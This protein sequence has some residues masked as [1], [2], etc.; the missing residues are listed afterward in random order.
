MLKSH[1]NNFI[2]SN[3]TISMPIS[4]FEAYKYEYDLIGFLNSKG[5]DKNYHWFIMILNNMSAP[6]QFLKDKVSIVIPDFGDIN[7]LKNVF[8]QKNTTF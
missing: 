5:I 8:I 7:L 2:N 1:Y 6:N 3:K 4:N